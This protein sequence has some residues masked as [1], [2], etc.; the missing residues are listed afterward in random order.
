MGNDQDTAREK[1]ELLYH[2]SRELASAIDLRT[3][4]SRVLSLSL[5]TVGGERASIVVLDDRGQPLDAAIVYGSRVLEH[6]TQQLRE[7]VDRG[8]AGWVVRNYKPALLPDTSRDSRWLRRPDDAQERSGAKSAICV[9]LL[10]RERLV[11]VLT[12]VHPSPGFFTEES[13]TLIQAVADQAGVTIL[14][15]RLY[16]ESQRQARIMTA[17]AENAFALHASLRL[18]EVLQRI[19]DQT[20]QALQVDVVLLGLTDEASQELVFQAVSG[21][22][23]RDLLGI[24]Q[25][26]RQG[27]IGRVALE[28]RGVVLSKVAAGT[29]VK[30]PGVEIH[31][32]VCAPVHAHGRI[33]GV[34]EAVNPR[35]SN[36]TTDALFLL[37]GIGSL[38]GIA[39]HNAQLYER[40]DAAHQRY[41][42]LF[43]DSI[44]PILITTFTGQIIEANR[45]ALQLSV[46][47]DED[48]MKCLISD[49]HRVDL[50]KV[51]ENYANLVKNE[52]LTYESD[53]TTSTGRAIPIEVH[54]RRI[55]IDGGDYLQ[56]IL[57]DVSEHKSLEALQDDLIAM[58]YHDLRAPLANIISS[59]DLLSSMLPVDRDPSLNAVLSIA[60]HSTDRMH[61]LIGSLLDIRR[62]EAGQKIADPKAVRS[63]L[64]VADALKAVQP[65]LEAKQ[66]D[67]LSSIQENLPDLWVDED[68]IRR[69]LINLLENACKFTPQ[70]GKIEVAAVQSGEWFKIWVQ[71]SGPGIPMAERDRIFEKF[72]RLQASDS[73]RGLG[74]GLSFCRLAIQAHQGEIWVEGQPGAGSRFVFT[75]PVGGKI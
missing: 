4:L 24:R 69:V 34:L 20:A 65:M 31:S 39:I 14:N 57:R 8:L 30:V 53:M 1:L 44:D 35:G 74:L 12:I 68:M 29:H 47:T 41:R 51:G 32:L 43:E 13:F 19:L 64:L 33:I 22:Q 23:A 18:E 27:T 9:P 17:L 49:L 56:W 42:E 2:I 45:Q 46:Y 26:L 48:L 38:A 5:S 75:L 70:K 36:L 10:S 52:S 21:N 61:R 59:L 71:D 15:A 11:G 55:D 3:V 40:L 73:P 58:V 67:A 62:L 66:Q 60:N 72:V 63:E 6:T 28:G 7:T 37:T 50:T 25:S 16:E 54:V